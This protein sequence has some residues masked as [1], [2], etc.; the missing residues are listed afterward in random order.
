MNRDVAAVRDVLSGHPPAQDQ[1]PQLQARRDATLRMV[2]ADRVPAQQ[3]RSSAT[4]RRSARLVTVGL[5]TV[6]TAVTMTQLGPTGASPAS[7]APATPRLLAYTAVPTTAAASLQ[8]L[9]TSVRALPTPDLARGDITYTKTSGW[10]LNTRIDGELV[11][12]VVLPEVRETWR[13]SD[14]SGRIRVAPGTPSFPSPQAEREWATDAPSLRTRDER[15]GAGEL[16]LMYPESLPSDLLG[17]QS[18]LAVGHP[19][20]NGP[21]ETLVAVADL[22][23]EQLP[24]PGVRASILDIVA[25][26]PGL[27]LLG[28]TVDREGRPGIAVG[29]ESTGSGLPTMHTLIFDPLD[30]RLLSEEQVLTRTAGALGVPVPSVISYTLHEEHVRVLSLD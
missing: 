18:A 10:Y 27:E 24:G 21:D 12:S 22:Y 8:D 25:S 3:R 23:R 1:D 26:L 14:G 28:E 20:E 6:L 30:G 17:L 4:R 9:A 16:A 2:L 29:I 7:A 5:L 13:R 11:T 19:V 15:V